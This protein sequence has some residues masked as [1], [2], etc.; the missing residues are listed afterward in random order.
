MINL[1]LLNFTISLTS[2]LNRFGLN[3]LSKTDLDG[4]DLHNKTWETSKETTG[5]FLS[6]FLD[7]NHRSQGGY[8]QTWS[9]EGDDIHSYRIWGGLETKTNSRN[10][11]IGSWLGS[12]PW[13]LCNHDKWGNLHFKESVCSFKIN[14]TT[15]KDRL[16]TKTLWY[17]FC[18]FFCTYLHCHF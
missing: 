18:V 6:T 3:I 12:F 15:S 9:A 13:E 17:F 8:Y 4:K 16:A 11:K 5:R 7:K 10:K 14:V 2:T 1:I